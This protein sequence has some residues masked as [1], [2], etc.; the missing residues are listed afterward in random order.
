MNLLLIV[1]PSPGHKN[2]IRMIDCSHEAKANYLWHPNDLL[3]ISSLCAPEDKIEFLDATES[4]LTSKD[5][6]HKLAGQNP[7][8]IITTLSSVCW[9]PDYAF[10]EQV[11]KL[12][13]GKP[14]F[15]LADIFLEQE[16][17]EF[18]LPQCSG[19]IASP[20]L[21]DLRQMAG[22]GAAAAGPLPGVITSVSDNPY[23]SKRHLSGRT[24]IPRHELFIDKSYCF[25]LSHHFNFATI[26]TM[27][28]CPFTCSYC[29]DS[30]TQP[31]VRETEDVVKE[32]EYLESLGVKELFFADKTFGFPPEN[33]RKLAEIMAERFH[34]SWCCYFH[35]QLYNEKL[36][37]TMKA[38][39]CHTLIVGIDSANLEQLHQFHRNVQKE[40]LEGLLFKADQLGISVC[41]DFIIGL[42]HETES[43]VRKTFDYALSRPLDFASFNIVAPL[44]GSDVRQRAKENGLLSFGK[45]GYDT[46]G[47]G[48][49]LSGAKISSVKLRQLRRSTTIQF[50]LRPAYILRRLRRTASLEHLVLQLR[51]MVVLFKKIY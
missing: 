49:I 15:V 17:R 20:Y 10:F 21:L 50:Y 2:I 40:K 5:A 35:P 12:F 33:A 41:A 24:F 6:L 27:W 18:M 51:Q 28:G 13:P 39:G 7:D 22:R 31:F 32:L 48:G 36:L 8:L 45:E 43:D 34:F 4:S 42:P 11:K 25:P 37:E 38:A 14:L 47:H 16:Y 1:P 29:S 30:K 9:G 23:P 19:I 26:T 44:P 46:F 3:I